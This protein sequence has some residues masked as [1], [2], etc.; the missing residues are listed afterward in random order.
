MEW[1]VCMRAKE[2]DSVHFSERDLVEAK[3]CLCH[4]D[5]AYACS[6]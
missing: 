3:I 5:S 1:C 4:V 6:M 2:S